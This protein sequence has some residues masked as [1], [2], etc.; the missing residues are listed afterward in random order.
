MY[1]P[2]TIQI[3]QHACKISFKKK[4][5]KK[6]HNDDTYKHFL[7]HGMAAGVCIRL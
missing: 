6:S 4:K 5:N 2:Y 7:I 3:Y 1:L